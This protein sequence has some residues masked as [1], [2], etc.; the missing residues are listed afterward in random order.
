MR[1]YLVIIFI[2][3]HLSS[4]GQI[5]LNSEKTD[6]SFFKKA[7]PVWIDSRNVKKNETDKKYSLTTSGR[8]FYYITELT[9]TLWENI[10][11]RASSNYGFASYIAHVF[12]HDLLGFGVVD[13]VNKMIVVTFNNLDIISC[14]G[15]L[16]VSDKNIKLQWEKTRTKLVYSYSAPVG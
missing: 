7:V 9:G 10:H 12:Y 4:I 13:P 14:K 8:N 1:Y 16:P 6:R 3:F 2:I 15:E 11:T 5:Q